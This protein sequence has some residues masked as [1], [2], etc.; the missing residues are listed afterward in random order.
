MTTNQIDNLIKLPK[1]NKKSIYK[2]YLNRKNLKINDETAEYYIEAIENLIDYLEKLSS[3]SLSHQEINESLSSNEDVNLKKNLNAI[4]DLKLA[5]RTS[6][7][8]LVI[9][10]FKFKMNLKWS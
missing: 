2:S 8:R 9:Y 7:L 5:L 4:E 10:I 6:P 1:E 3:S